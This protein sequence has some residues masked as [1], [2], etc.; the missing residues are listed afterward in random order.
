MAGYQADSGFPI[1]A[2][3]Q[4]AYNRWLSDQAHTRGL[5]IVLKNDPEQAAD[6]VGDFDL[7]IVEDCAVFRFCDAFLP[8]I[9]QGKPVFQVEYN[10]RF[11]SAS[12][13]CA[14]SRELGYSAQ[15]KHRELDAWSQPCR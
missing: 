11:A 6:L 13:F 7:A 10:D 3:D 8:F 5:L 2:S 12:A 9:P 4:L 1:T 14:E 15:L